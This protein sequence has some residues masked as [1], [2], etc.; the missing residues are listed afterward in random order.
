VIVNAIS[1]SIKSGHV[2]VLDSFT[3]DYTR[4]RSVSEGIREEIAKASGAGRTCATYLR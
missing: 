2:T 3:E 1:H 4:I